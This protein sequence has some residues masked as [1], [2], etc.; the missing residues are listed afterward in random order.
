MRVFLLI[1]ALA[2]A[3]PALAETSE[4]LAPPVA[5]TPP[6]ATVQDARKSTASPLRLR[7]P[8]LYDGRRHPVNPHEP[9]RQN[10][11]G[12]GIV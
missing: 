9:S 6:V 5:V 12:P 8:M 3:A 11:A 1:A 10:A 2:V 4:P 7:E